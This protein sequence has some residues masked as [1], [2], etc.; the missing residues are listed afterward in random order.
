MA[1]VDAAARARLA[2]DGYLVVPGL[3]D[4]E[5]DLAPLRVEY[6]AL[7]DTVAVQLASEGVVSSVHPD[8]PFG[9]RFQA[10]VRETEGTLANHLDIC[11]PQKGVT[12]D[13]PV[14][15]GPAAFG[16]LTN[17]RLLDAVEVMV[18]PR[19]LLQPD[20]TR[21]DQASRRVSRGSC[22]DCRRNRP[23]CLA[24]GPGDDHAG[25]GR[26]PDSDGVAADHRSYPRKRLPAG[27]AGQSPAGSRDALSR[28]T[29][30]LQPPGDTRT[31]GRRPSRRAGDGTR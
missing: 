30:E 10:L 28:S 11:L 7:L 13:T 20:P 25:S 4:P 18:G 2:E 14:H 8:L 24:P 15:C 16:L 1:T 26:Q 21:A 19:D 9:E 23:D 3:L 27:R 22:Y 31:T 5:R 17:P 6:E 12:T 29:I